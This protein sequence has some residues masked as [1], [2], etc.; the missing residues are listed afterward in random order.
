MAKCRLLMLDIMELG[1]MI[2]DLNTNYYKALYAS[3][4]V[5]IVAFA[6]LFIYYLT[7]KSRYGNGD[8]AH[9]ST[10]DAGTLCLRIAF[11]GVMFI[12]PFL[13]TRIVQAFVC[14]EVEGISYLR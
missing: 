6:L 10:R 7:I 1:G 12:Y 5:V 8:A 4:A 3:T 11:Y 2:C 9:T 13:S 14:R